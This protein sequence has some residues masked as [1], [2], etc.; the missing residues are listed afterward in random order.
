MCTQTVRNALADAG[1]RSCVARR[2]P[3]LTDD[4]MARRLTWAREHRNWTVQQWR[5]VE[6]SGV[7]VPQKAKK[8]R[9]LGKG[10]EERLEGYSFGRP[11][12]FG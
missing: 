10:S 5:R 12:G 9:R 11:L 6:E 1:L 8:P 2:K 3:F 4:H 7:R